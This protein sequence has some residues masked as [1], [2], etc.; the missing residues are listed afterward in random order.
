[1]A[2]RHALALI[3]RL[4]AR[5]LSLGAPQ[6]VSTEAR[7]AN[8]PVRGAP[9]HA[10][11]G[12]RWDRHQIPSIEAASQHDLAV[13]IGVVHAHLRL[14]QLEAMRRLAT[15][16]VA[17]AIGPA[18]I[19]LDRAI[20]LM[21]LTR[22]VP[23]IEAMLPPATRLWAEGFVAGINHVITHAPSLPH[24]FH[25]LRL[26]PTPWTLRDLLSVSRLAATDMSW[27]VFARVLRARTR[28]DPAAWRALWPML[29]GG[30]NIPSPGSNSAA[31]AASASATG[32]GLI[33]SDPH[34]SVAQPPLWL[35]A[36][37]HAPGLDA[38]GLMIPGNPGDR[39]GP[40]PRARLGGHQPA[41]REQR[42][43]RCRRR[44][45]RRARR[46]HPR[47]RRR[48]RLRAAAP[49]KLRPGGQR[50]LVAALGVH[51]SHCVGSAIA[52]ATN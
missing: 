24:E 17:E 26:R 10:R 48:T 9:S 6:P 29:Q 4:L 7:L 28:L 20:L 2:D 12:I 5:A 39:A 18:G 38:V 11:L 43:R 35:I 1:M 49:H 19:E 21:D 22:A 47:P 8:I 45:D 31:V 40:Q 32:A 14:A 23:E 36:A 41:R 37:L 50:R 3:A 16:R 33:A 13:G 34:L 30:D 46:E 51:R 25:L 42:P 44:A 15:A 52:P 27:L